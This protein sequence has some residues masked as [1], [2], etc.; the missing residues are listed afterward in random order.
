M[1]LIKSYDGE[2]DNL[3]SAERFFKL[4]LDLPFYRLRTEAMFLKEDF[5]TAIESIN[6][7][8][9]TI[10][11]AADGFLTNSSFHSFLA[12]VLSTGNF[13]NTV[14]ERL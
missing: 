1:D 11:A 12:F 9:D 14:I 5:V 8:L 2:L 6:K 7:N 4:I 10:M 13:L 3:G